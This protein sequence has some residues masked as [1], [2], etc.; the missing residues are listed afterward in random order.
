[1]RQPGEIGNAEQGADLD[2]RRRLRDVRHG[3]EEQDGADGPQM[4][5]LGRGET[6]A[7]AFERDVG[8]D[9]VAD[10]DDA[11]EGLAGS[12]AGVDALSFEDVEGVVDDGGEAERAVLEGIF[13]GLE[14]AE[15]LAVEGEGDVF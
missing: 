11:V 6:Q 5:G 2:P 4:S 12:G 1:V 3:G 8:A 7:Q 10:E 14:A 13:S 15:A 9:G